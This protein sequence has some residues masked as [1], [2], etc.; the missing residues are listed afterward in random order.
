[1]DLLWCVFVCVC[2]DPCYHL[3]TL[4]THM[5]DIDFESRSNQLIDP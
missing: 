4:Q 5:A 2:V 1:M 3:H